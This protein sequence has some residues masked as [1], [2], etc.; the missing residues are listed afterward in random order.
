MAPGSAPTLWLYTATTFVSALLLFSVQPLFAKMVLPVLGGSPS[1][2][3]VA[4]CFFQAALLAGYVYAHLLIRFLPP[5]AGG[6]VHLTV[7]AVAL[8]ALPIGIPASW[9]EPPAG[10]PYLWQ[11]SLFAIAI[12]P[13][14]FAVAANA[15]LLQAWFARSGHP[16]AAD[17][18][19]LYGASNLGSLIALLAYPVLLEPFAGLKTQAGIWTAGFIVLGLMI[20]TCG[21][22][23]VGRDTSEAASASHEENVATDRPT[24]VQRAGW[25]CLAFV[26]S[27]LLVAFTSY[28]TTDIAS[29]P[30]LW[31]IPLAMFLAT[32]ILVFR[33]PPM[34]SHRLMLLLQPLLTTIVLFGIA[35]T[36][37][38][39]WM[40]AAV[41]GTLAFFVT[42]M[43]CHKELYDQRPSSR[44]VTEFYLWM[45]FGGV[46]GGIF[47]ALVAP[48][49]F[50]SIWEFPLLLVLGMAMRPGLLTRPGKQAL[51]ELAVMG[52]AVLLVLVL[53]AVAL[54]QGWMTVV[55]AEL[56]RMAIIVGVGALAVVNSSS[57][58]RQTAFI[59]LGALAVVLL[60]SAMNRGDAERSFFGVHRVT[61]I[62]NGQVRTLLHGTTIHGAQ[63]IKDEEGRAIDRPVPMVYY[64]PGGPAARGV[65][66]SRRAAGK[67]AADFVPAWWGSALVPW[68]ATHRQANAGGS[69][70]RSGGAEDRQQSEAVYVL[71]SCQPDADVVLGDARLTMAK[72][73]EG[74]FDFLLIDAFSSDAVPVH[75]LTK[76]AISLYLDK[77]EP[78]GILALHVS[79]RHMDL[80]TVAS[81]TAK[82]LPGIFVG[83]ADER[84]DSNSLDAAPSHVV[85]VTRSPETFREVLLL[86]YVSAVPDVGVTPWT[87]DF[88]NIIS[89]LWRKAAS[90]QK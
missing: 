13:P 37:S 88:S 48:Q 72:E 47:A 89:A 80:H 68:R 71:S 44:H 78:N 10:D 20:A 77:L 39:G 52:G 15:P 62:A 3:A 69:R 85:F 1:V 22:L 34:I 67:S 36:G 30:F 31:V 2:W 70:D 9:H 57:A 66:L 82:A 59:A 81:A 86:P 23:S 33:D 41:G 42:T 8:V 55:Q 51:R 75:L 64:H 18:Y 7:F 50:N 53:V 4:M 25:V 76:E 12:G 74:S 35:M 58:L 11:M 46:L 29:A 5:R 83:L 84:V 90:A 14:F 54:S 63:R 6:F 49:L 38:Q 79:N 28:V 27:G 26:P 17:P 87:D 24:W 60:P 21:A 32:F 61:T 40:M 43:V 19:F 73:R 56:G 45:S 16:H 65:A